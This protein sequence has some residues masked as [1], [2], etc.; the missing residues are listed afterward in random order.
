MA[1]E[2]A[3]AREYWGLS[4]PLPGVFAA[5]L[6]RNVTD[7]DKVLE[8]AMTCWAPSG[9]LVVLEYSVAGS[10]RSRASG[11]WSAGRW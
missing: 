5:Y 10:R 6:F 1:E 8:A 9:S 4:D 7:R 11:P 3:F 2:L